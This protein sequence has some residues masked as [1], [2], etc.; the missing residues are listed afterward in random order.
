MTFSLNILDWCAL[1]PG[2]SNREQWR[3]WS[4]LSFDDW[5]APL[6]PTPHIPMMMAR[7]MSAPSRLSVEVGMTLL[8]QQPDAAIFVSRHGELERT[9]KII[10]S[11][12]RQQDVSPT[13]FAMSVHNTAAGL[14]TI[15]GKA[16]LPMTSLAAGMDG[17]QQGMLEAQAVLNA[18]AQ[19]VLLVDFDGVI[20]EAYSARI[21]HTVPAY[22]V[23]L[24]IAQGQTLRCQAVKKAPRPERGADERPQ[25]LEFLRHY[26]TCRNLTKESSFIIKGT[27]SDW[28]WNR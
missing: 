20:P 25:S 3:Q 5:S 24:L 23:G 21:T 27:G 9:Y 8:E 12:C 28:Q 26:L 7:R 14:L 18:G 19:K 17:F 13:D 16:P 10:E 4:S 6:P 2:L 1:A 15:G 11:L 22:A